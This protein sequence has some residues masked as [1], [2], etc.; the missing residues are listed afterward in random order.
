M[1]K[2]EVSSPRPAG[3]FCHP[4]NQQ[5]VTQ[6]RYTSKKMLKMKIDPDMCMKT[7]GE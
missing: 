6:G 4:L 5:N 2:V 1:S 3:R 7:N